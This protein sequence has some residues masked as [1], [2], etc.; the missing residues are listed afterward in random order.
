[1]TDLWKNAS[2]F[3]TQRPVAI[4]DQRPGRTSPSHQFAGIANSTM[5]VWALNI[6]PQ[7]TTRRELQH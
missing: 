4:V 2:Q 5:Y 1:M 3:Y 7:G 6:E